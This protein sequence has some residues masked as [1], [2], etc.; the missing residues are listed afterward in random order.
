MGLAHL[1]ARLKSAVCVNKQGYLHVKLGETILSAVFKVSVP[2]ST[3]DTQEKK[4]AQ[5]DDRGLEITSRRSPAIL[6]LAS[7]ACW[8][9]AAFEAPRPLIGY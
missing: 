5:G 8:M 1:D 4:W 7:A 9:V 6:Q 2:S 3:W